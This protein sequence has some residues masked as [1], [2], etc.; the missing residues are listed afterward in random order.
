MVVHNKAIKELSPADYLVIDQEH[1]LLEKFLDD[2]RDAC[3]CSNL[4]Q[5]T[6]CQ[7]C[8][9]EK[10]ISCQGRIASFLFCVINLT[11]KHFEHEEAIMLSRPHVTVEYEYFRLHRE[12]HY[13]IMNKLHALTDECFSLRNRSNPSEIY[14]QF[15]E[16]LSDLFEEHNHSFDDPFLQSTKI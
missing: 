7:T 12:A 11:G 6:D 5:L 9:H 10:M 16:I 2:L 14:H 1:K 13:E 3:A 15:Y 4:N 8:D